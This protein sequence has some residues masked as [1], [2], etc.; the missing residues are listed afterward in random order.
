MNGCL[1]YYRFTSP[2]VSEAIATHS[3]QVKLLHEQGDAIAAAF[4]GK[5]LY[6]FSITGKRFHGLVFTPRLISPLWTKPD[7]KNGHVQ[8][9]RRG[10]GLAAD[11]QAMLELRERWDALAPTAS[12]D[13]DVVYKACGT[14]WGALIF[15]GGDFNI[16]GD[17]V[18]LVTRIDL[19]ATG[20]EITGG[21]FQRAT[22]AVQS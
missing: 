12:V 11:R 2:A 13:Y 22:T 1:R 20:E 5:P 16:V 17:M 14:D 7:A 8:W 21:E 10:K 15:A 19:T 9:P 6:S 18:Y 4:G 3:A